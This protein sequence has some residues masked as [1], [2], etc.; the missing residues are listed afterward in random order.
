M[1]SVTQ[2]II[3]LYD[4]QHLFT[5]PAEKWRG[6]CESGERQSPVH[7]DPNTAIG[8]NLP[9][10]TVLNYRSRHHNFKMVNTG[11]GGNYKLK[12]SHNKNYSISG[13]NYS[14]PR[15]TPTAWNNVNW[16][17]LTRL[18]CIRKYPL[19]LEWYRAHL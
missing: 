15:N 17:S 9:P 7:I 1:S 4:I 2:A 13:F 3:K 19:A 12:N 10:L 18:L 14:E 6:L 16:W 11:H 5:L 8:S